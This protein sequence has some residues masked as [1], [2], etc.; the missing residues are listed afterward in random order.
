MEVLKI[1]LHV[2]IE[3]AWTLLCPFA[4]FVGGGG[5]ALGFF[6]FFFKADLFRN[7]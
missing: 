5:V 4:V 7:K 3:H 1:I 2:S 6:V